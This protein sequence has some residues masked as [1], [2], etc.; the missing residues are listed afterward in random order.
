MSG[1]SHFNNIVRPTLPMRVLNIS[2]LDELVRNTAHTIRNTN[3]FFYVVGSLVKP[4][5]QGKIGVLK[6]YVDNH[7][8]KE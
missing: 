5:S 3:P 2:F 8:G 7:I 4:V 6:F 1:A